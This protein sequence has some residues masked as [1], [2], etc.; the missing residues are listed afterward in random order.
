MM[1]TG[2]GFWPNPVARAP[3]HR[4]GVDRAQVLS[5]SESECCHLLAN[6]LL[7]RWPDGN[8]CYCLCLHR[9]APS[10]Q[11]GSIHIAPDIARSIQPLQRTEHIASVAKRDLQFVEQV[12]RVTLL[13]LNSSP[14]HGQNAQIYPEIDFLKAIA[15][16]LTH[17]FS[18]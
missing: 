13:V 17:D 18:S 15:Q 6:R 10:A 5:S 8:N 12:P 16:M 9:I 14:V 1:A 7:D 4:G 11:T 2:K 3:T